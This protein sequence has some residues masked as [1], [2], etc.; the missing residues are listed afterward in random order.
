MTEMY[1]PELW[2]E[3]SVVCRYYESRKVRVLGA[4][5]AAFTS[6]ASETEGATADQCT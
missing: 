6:G 1:S 3:G 2:H 5:V 4:N